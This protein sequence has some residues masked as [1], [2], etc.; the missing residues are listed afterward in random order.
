MSSSGEGGISTVNT[1]LALDRAGK[2]NTQVFR[3]YWTVEINKIVTVWTGDVFIM[4]F[5]SNIN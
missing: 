2:K 5:L 4:F 3:L 1:R